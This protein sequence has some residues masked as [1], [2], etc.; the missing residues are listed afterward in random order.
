MKFDIRNSDWTQ[1]AVA[2]GAQ[3]ANLQADWMKLFTSHASNPWTM[4]KGEPFS[5]S[6][7]PRAAEAHKPVATLPERGSSDD[8]FASLAT[9]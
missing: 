5:L 7:L 1:L 3:A 6:M 4:Q 9:G 8:V 2:F